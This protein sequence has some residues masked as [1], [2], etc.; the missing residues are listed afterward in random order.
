MSGLCVAIALLRDGIRDVAIYEKAAEV[1]GTWR[2]H[3]YPGL[4]CD[5]PSR[6]YQY[7]FARTRTGCACSR[8]AAIQA[9][10]QGIADRVRPQ[11]PDL[12]RHRSRQ[13]PTRRWPLGAAHQYRSRIRGGLPDLGHRRVLHH[14][15]M[16][17]IEGLGD[18]GGPFF[19]RRAGIIRSR[20][21]PGASRLSAM[22]RPGSS[23]SAVLPA[24][25]GGCRCFSA[26]R[27]GSSL[28][29]TRAT[30]D[31]PSARTESFRGSPG[32][33]LRPTA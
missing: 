11:A 9:Y 3:T 21:G 22:S 16:P 12:V 4:T 2:D 8:R 1:S 31:S 13:R 7:S 5:V 10:F 14:P 26:P 25:W 19:T 20:C 18:F 17:A 30:A 23:S 32:W 33:P 29:P 6:V 28:C 24:W 15:R 27:N